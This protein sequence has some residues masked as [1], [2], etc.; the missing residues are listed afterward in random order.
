MGSIYLSSN[1]LPVFEYYIGNDKDCR[2]LLG[3]GSNISVVDISKRDLS[4]LFPRAMST[5]IIT[6]VMSA[7]GC[8]QSNIYL[9]PVFYIAEMT[10]INLPVAVA[11]LSKFKCD[12]ILSSAIFSNN[13]LSIDCSARHLS[14]TTGIM[15]TID[16]VIYEENGIFKGCDYKLI[17]T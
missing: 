3:I 8:V 12:M 9:I 10:V 6:D 15:R 16:C 4:E 2:I 1:R 5:G 7:N 17:K 13:A 11:N 14:V